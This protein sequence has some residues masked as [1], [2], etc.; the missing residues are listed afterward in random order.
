ME[1]GDEAGCGGRNEV[2]ER[3][4][5]T[6]ESSC[7]EIWV[8]CGGRRPNREL[9]PRARRRGRRTCPSSSTS[10]CSCSH[11]C[12]H[13]YS[14]IFLLLAP[15][16]RRPDP[17]AASNPPCSADPLSSFLD[18]RYLGIR[19]RFLPSSHSRSKGTQLPAQTPPSLHSP[20][21]SP[22]VLQ[23]HR[24]AW[25]PLHRR[26]PPPGSARGPERTTWSRKTLKGRSL[27]PRD[28]ILATT[29]HAS[30]RRGTRRS[31]REASSVGR[32]KSCWSL[33]EEGEEE[34]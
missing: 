11:R 14:S 16:A 27:L 12:L 3:G 23:R 24:R 33:V 9:C 20:A 6:Q 22:P 32:R 4:W 19:S 1:N 31:R 29:S 17:P 10:C 30:R 7:R 5:M 28:W 15:S 18:P 34:I 8:S 21:R 26:S 2:Y 13:H 25:A